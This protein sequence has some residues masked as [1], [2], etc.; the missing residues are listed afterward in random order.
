MVQLTKTLSMVQLPVRTVGMIISSRVIVGSPV[1]ATV[2]VSVPLALMPPVNPLKKKLVELF[3]AGMVMGLVI[4]VVQFRSRKNS[5]VV[6]PVRVKVTPLVARL[7]K[8][9]R[10]STVR[11]LLQV[12]AS[13]VCVGVV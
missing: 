6:E 7:P 13:R 12:P 5:A 1:G 9:S 3:P 11:M 8:A 10:A 2:S 4:G